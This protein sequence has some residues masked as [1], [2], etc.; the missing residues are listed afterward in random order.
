MATALLFVFGSLSA[1]EHSAHHETDAHSHHPHKHHVAIFN[2]ATSNLTHN[3]TAYTVGFDYEYRFSKLVGATV[4]GEYISTSSSEI[5]AG[6]GLLFHPYKAFKFVGAP[7]AIFAEEHNEGH[8]PA[9]HEDGKKEASF[10]FR[11]SAGYDFYAG[12]ISIGPVVNY[13][14]G[15]TDAISYG[16]AVGIGF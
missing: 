16:V 5:I 14:L 11:F 7:L 6:A 2:G 15:K 8:Q 9:H 13:D 12:N 3:N 1:Q 4:I 10:A